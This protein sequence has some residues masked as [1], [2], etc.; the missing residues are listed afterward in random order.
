[1]AQ[2]DPR[3]S[4]SVATYYNQYDDLRSL[5]PQNP[6][7]PV[8]LVVVNGQQ[9]ESY[10]AELTA[11]YRATDAWR[12]R[13]GINELR[14]YIRPKPG[15]LDQSFGAGE[16]ADSNHHLLLRSSFD[17][18]PRLNLD[19]TFR[20]VSRIIN[21]TQDVPGY[22]ELDARLAWQPTPAL[23]LSITG[24]NLLHDRHVEFGTQDARQ[25]IQRTVY[26]KAVWRF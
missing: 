21:P 5:V 2:P 4:I 24:Q 7:L 22:C 1:R 20:A 10:G 3:V 16:A 26:A 25:A 15:S 18:A 6:A 8:P 9:G 11:D 23:E 12:L 14:V 17:L 13:V 19:A